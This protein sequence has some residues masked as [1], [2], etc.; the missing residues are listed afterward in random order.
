M[1]LPTNNSNDTET[2]R[3]SFSIWGWLC[4][5]YILFRSEGFVTEIQNQ[6]C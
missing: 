4:Q 2:E 5:P 6:K 3:T 1:K